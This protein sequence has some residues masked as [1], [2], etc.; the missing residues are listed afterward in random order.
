M[1]TNLQN[2]VNRA[3]ALHNEVNAQVVRVSPAR[4][5]PIEIGRELFYQ[6]DATPE[7]FEASELQEFESWIEYWIKDRLNNL[8]RRYG[9]D[10][11]CYYQRADFPRGVPRAEK[12]VN[13]R[14]KLEGLEFVPENEACR[15]Q[16]ESRTDRLECEA[17]EE[18]SQIVDG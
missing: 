17:D 14:H 3:P 18:C 10:S 15:F 8:A 9:L 6:F 13:L 11:E 16:L 1:T 2:A 7:E 5:P 12:L 4:C